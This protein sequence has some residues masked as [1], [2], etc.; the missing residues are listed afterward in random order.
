MS[1]AVEAS[2]FLGAILHGI[3]G[4]C[5]AIFYAPNHKAKGWSWETYW[6][7]QSAFCW[8]IMPVV[9]AALTI[10]E[11][12]QVLAEA[13]KSAML[14][15]WAFGAV[16]GVG[17]IAFGIAI[18]YI[19]YS[20]T[21]AIAIGIS[22]VLGT[23]VPE[24]VAGTLLQKLSA[25]GGSIITIGLIIG[26]VGMFLAGYAGFNKDKDLGAID[27][28]KGGFS[29]SKGLPLCVLSGFLSAVFNFAL[30]AGQPIADVAAQYGAGYMQGNVVFIF[31]M[32]GA[33]CTSFVYCLWM[34]AKNKTL[35][36]Y[37]KLNKAGVAPLPL[38]F[39][40]AAAGGSLWYFQFFFYGMGHT[41]MGEFS[42][43]SWAL[44]MSLLIFFS[45][46]LGLIMR[47]WKN[48]R[49][50]TKTWINVG[51]VVIV[52][53]VLTIAWGNRKAEVS[54]KQVDEPLVER[55]INQINE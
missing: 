27:A 17:G 9:I 44:H 8:L 1:M 25:T 11:I 51:L 7:V 4:L 36:E 53:S 32:G 18:K 15:S 5:A 16:Y 22:A 19:G 13:P 38:H 10:P 2:P 49:P 37:T 46:L 29:L 21:Y 23:M 47:E 39:V 31:A 45:N 43:T 42:F 30:N 28:T 52:I 48:C 26:V 40:L 3:G 34:G 6:N 55:A 14:K 50:I 24:I 41:R 12:G 35:S 20:L 33:F 54:K